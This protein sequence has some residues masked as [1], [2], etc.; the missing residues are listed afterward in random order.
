[1]KIIYLCLLLSLGSA[2][3]SATPCAATAERAA[4]MLQ[5]GNSKSKLLNITT[6]SDLIQISGSTLLYSV[7][8]YE[9]RGNE[10]MPPAFYNVQAMGSELHCKISNIE[11]KGFIY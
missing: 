2:A 1:M 9:T 7:Q 4:A 3:Q 5:A 11:L 10:Q 6:D 8:V